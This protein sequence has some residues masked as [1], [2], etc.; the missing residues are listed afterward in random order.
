MADDVLTLEKMAELSPEAL[1][2]Y[3]IA[4]LNL[5]SAHRLPGTEELDIGAILDKLDEW[6]ERVQ[7][8]IWRH[9]Y[10]HDP[11]TASPPDVFNYGNSLGRFFCWYLLQVLQEDCGVVYHPDRK[12]DPDFCEPQDVFIH[13][14]IV[15][16]GKGGT[17]ASMPV[18]YVAVGRRI[19]LPLY[20]VGTRG[21]L[22]FRWDDPKG[23]TINWE[24]QG[25]HLW[26]PPDRFNVEGS[27][28]GI[29]YRPDSHYIQWP[30]LWTEVDFDHGRY[31]RSQTTAEDVADF[32]MQRSECFYELCNW[33]EC[34]KAIHYARKFS[35]DDPRLKGTHA[36]RTKEIEEKIRI[37]ES[38]M[39]VEAW[40]REQRAKAKPAVEGHDLRGFCA[41]CRKIRSLEQSRPVMEHGSSCRRRHCTEIREIQQAATL[42]L[43][44]HG[45]S[46]QCRQC[47]TARQNAESKSGLPGH[48][49]SCLCFG[50]QQQR[51]MHSPNHATLPFPTKPHLPGLPHQPIVNRH[52]PPGLPG[53]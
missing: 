53:T 46:C 35:P 32:L 17:C 34:L 10:Q 20:L 47:Q 14:M 26:I 50:C 37:R 39:M 13:G 6:A 15:E 30:E 52:Q 3:D 41:H 36:K 42:G 7:W 5:W 1:E 40:N 28:E 48:P 22:F 18:L 8:E 4:L 25:L 24:R 27:G 45:P 49:A 23:T 29:A 31:L 16:G 44:N 12:F 33:E 43:P 11:R 2:E 51:R 9:I 21:H 19:G 38:I